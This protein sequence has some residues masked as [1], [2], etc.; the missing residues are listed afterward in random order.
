MKE[1][2]FI[3]IIIVE[4]YYPDKKF[5]R[6]MKSYTNQ[7]YGNY[8]IIL[9]HWGKKKPNEIPKILKKNNIDIEKIKFHN[10][11]F[12][13]GYAKGNNLG[14]NKAKYEF[15]LIS[16]P[17]IIAHPGF[18]K[19]MIKSFFYLRTYNETD[20]L[21][22]S[23][24]ICNYD[25]K[26]EYSRRKINFLGFSNIDFS[27]TKKIRRTMII[28]GCVFLIKRKYYEKLKGFDEKYFM[29]HEDIDFSIRAATFGVKMY[30]DNTINFFHLILSDTFFKLSKFK[31]YYIERNR[32]L[33]CLEHSKK[34]KKML[35]V[36]LLI[37]PLN[38]I[39]ALFK[40][41]VIERFKIY[42]F[43]IKNYSR[44]MNK[45]GKEN[46]YFDRFYQMDGIFN[47]PNSNSKIVYSILNL[48][49]KMLFYLYHH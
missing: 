30:I 35:L 37:E 47:N 40:G 25:R 9:I 29:Y 23:P 18:L 17:D 15:I 34:K 5:I 19:K 13:P 39:F 6:C 21:I 48:Y 10:Y 32:L 22:L 16:N 49:A 4:P 3:S 33:M 26:I 41:L 2:P 12:N 8:E 14:V 27:K 36:Q 43:I 24:R 20:K 42:K 38:L 11:N 1:N 44:I 45:K 46:T 28:S 31:Y 7:T